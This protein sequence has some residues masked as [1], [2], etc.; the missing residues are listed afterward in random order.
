[1]FQ[2]WMKQD[3][4]ST[5]TLPKILYQKSSGKPLLLENFFKIKRQL[6]KFI[7]IVIVDGFFMRVLN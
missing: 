7:F 2:I 1:M 5:I 3:Q 6:M 4:N